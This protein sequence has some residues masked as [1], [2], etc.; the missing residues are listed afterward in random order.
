VAPYAVDLFDISVT[1]H[2]T[3]LTVSSHLEEDAM[4]FHFKKR[5]QSFRLLYGKYSGYS[6][7]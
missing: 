3:A 7:N 6:R 5:A 2:S 1:T 4:F